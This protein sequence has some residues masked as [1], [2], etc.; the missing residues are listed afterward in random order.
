MQQSYKK[1]TNRRIPKPSIGWPLLPV[2]QNGTLRYPDLNESI[3]QYIKVLLLT[4]KGELLMRPQFGAGL[5]QFLH[6]PNVFETR[7]R[8]Q[9][10]VLQAL[11][12]WERRIEVNRVDVWEGDKPDQ[13]RI[14]ID[15][16]VKR[17][18]EGT[19]TTI[20]MMLGS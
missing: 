5:T 17:T 19:K 6:L 1:K 14:E 10:T 8:I 20:T 4:R 3:K 9:Q 18:G 11:D 16:R 12:A 2:P 15:Y 13:I 7:H